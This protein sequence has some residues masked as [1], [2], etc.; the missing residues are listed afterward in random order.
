M[1]RV[2][3][4]RGRPECRQRDS[5]PQGYC[6]TGSARQPNQYLLGVTDGI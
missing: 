4:Y 5:N 2:P 3:T 1:K 6:F